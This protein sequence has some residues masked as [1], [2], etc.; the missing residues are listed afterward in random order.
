MLLGGF[1]AVIGGCMILAVYVWPSVPTLY[2]P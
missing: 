1:A 2:T